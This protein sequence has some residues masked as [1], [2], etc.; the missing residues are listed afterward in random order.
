MAPGIHE[1][2]YTACDSHFFCGNLFRFNY[3]II[4]FIVSLY[5]NDLIGTILHPCKEVRVIL[6]DST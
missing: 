2:L 6:P 3:S 1:I 5:L 4:N